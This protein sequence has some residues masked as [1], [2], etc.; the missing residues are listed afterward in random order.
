MLIV[1]VHVRVVADGVDA[2][3]EATPRQRPRQRAGA[4]RRA[5]RR[6]PAGRRP[7]ALRADRDLPHAGGRR[8]AQGDGALRHLARRGG[9]AD[10]RAALEHQI[11]RRLPRAR[12]C[13]ERPRG[14]EFATASRIVFGAGRVR[15]LPALVGGRRTL[16]VTGR[17]GSPIADRRG[18]PRPRRRRADRSTTRV[19][20]P[21]PSPDVE[22]VVAIGGGSALDLGK[23]AAALIANGG[24]PLR[25]LEVIGE[26]Q[27]LARPS[28]P[29][30]AVPTTA[31]TGSEVTRNAVLG[32]PA[33]GVKAS[34]RSPH[35]LPA[36]GAGRSR[37]DLR[38]AAGAHRV[39]RPRRADAADRAVRQRQR[40]PVRRRDLPRRDPAR[41]RRAAEGVRRRSR[42][43][44]RHGLRQPV[45]RPRARQRRPRRRARLRRPDRRPLPRAARRGLRGA[46]APR[47]GD[48][49]ARAPAT[50]SSPSSR[51]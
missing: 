5:L 11:P 48:E 50:R 34:L 25:Y 18:A 31:G 26:G 20:R 14:F 23:A 9:A 4:G 6:H 33:H 42:R 15:E 30:I 41:D 27:P 46:A 2:F 8:G 24:D 10:G 36:R 45:R 12:A 38:P 28:L 1:H 7:D 49:R 44:R 35:M 47:R 17:R 40:E 19:E 39:H 3:R 32:S 51:P 22:M 37:A 29:C 43:A 21:R 16:L 13:R